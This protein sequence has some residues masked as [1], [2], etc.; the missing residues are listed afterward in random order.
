MKMMKRILNQIYPTNYIRIGNIIEDSFECL[1]FYVY[2]LEYSFEDYEQ[3]KIQWSYQTF[4]TTIWLTLN[5]WINIFYI[6]HLAFFPNYF[7][8]KSL[9]SFERAFQ[10]ERVDFLLQYQITMFIIVECL[11]FKFLKNILSYNYPFNNLMQRYAYYFD[12]NKLKSEYRQYLTRFIHTGNFISKTLN[13]MMTIL[14]IIFVIRSI[15]L[16]GQLFDQ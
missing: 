5:S 11:W 4:R 14:I 15:Y 6:V 2:R 10:F 9:K 12:D 1:K 13:M 3:R 16:I 8:W 7:L